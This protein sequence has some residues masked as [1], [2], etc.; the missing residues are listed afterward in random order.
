MKNTDSTI[1]KNQRISKL[2]GYHMK[3]E[4]GDLDFFEHENRLRKECYIKGDSLIFDIEGYQSYDITLRQIDTT[5]NILRWV[6]RL[7]DKAWM[8]KDLMRRFIEIASE[9][10]E[11]DPWGGHSAG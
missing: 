9:Q 4:Q 7:C 1:I 6:I 3:D 2:K 10:I 11:F 5:D 8:R